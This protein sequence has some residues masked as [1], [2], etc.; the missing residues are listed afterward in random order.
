MKNLFIVNAFINSTEKETVV[1]RALH[2]IRKCGHKIMIV[3]N[4][5]LSERIVSLCDYY[6]YDKEEY[7]LPPEKSPVKWYGDNKEIIYV[8]GK[9]NSLSVV[10]NLGTALITAKS[11]GFERFITLEYDNIVHDDELNKLQHWFS[12]LKEKHVVCCMSISTEGEW[13]DSRMFGGTIA[14]FTDTIT[15]PRTYEDWGRTIYGSSTCLEQYYVSVIQP[16]K[17]AVMFFTGTVQDNF[18]KSKIDVMYTVANVN[19]VYN[20]N[21]PYSPILFLIGTNQD[22]L[23]KINDHVHSEYISSGNWQKY[24]L[25]IKNNECQIEVTVNNKTLRFLVSRDNIET[26]KSSAVRVQ[27]ESV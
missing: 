9:G 12:L 10:R 22:Y 21:D 24:M 26:Y 17:D 20:Q 25:D 1:E 14:F 2:Q 15:L 18:P 13:I 8:Y 7:M 4:S 5:I 23:I 19:I 6:V 3:S 16:H 11:L 27:H